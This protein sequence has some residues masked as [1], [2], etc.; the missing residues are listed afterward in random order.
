MGLM[1]LYDRISTLLVRATVFAYP[2]LRFFN[3]LYGPWGRPEYGTF[4]ITGSHS[5][6]I[7]AIK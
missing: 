7:N 3:G 4:S 5:T 2:G 6:K 1:A